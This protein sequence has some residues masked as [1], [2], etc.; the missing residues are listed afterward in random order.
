M[1]RER[2]PVQH[3]PDGAPATVRHQALIWPDGEGW[4]GTAAGFIREGIRRRE[5]VSVGVS[6]RARARLEE[7]ADEDPLVEFFD[8]TQVGRNPGRII[9]VML[10]F[11][12]THAGQ[13]LRYLSE[14]AWAGRSDAEYAEAVRHEV[15]IELAFTDISATILC[16]YAAGGLTAP[17]LACAEQTHSVID[18]GGQRGP[19]GR[20]VGRGVLPAHCDRPLTPPPADA[21]VLSYRS[22]LAPVRVQV[23]A[24]AAEAGLAPERV[25]DLVLAASEVAAN[26]LRHAGGEGTLR[27]W[28][29]DG[30]VVCEITDAGCITDPLT[31]RR[32][33][34][35]DASGQGLWVVNQVCD[36]VELRSGKDGT[37][38]RMHVRL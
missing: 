13:P 37:T 30:E 6:D 29:A 35:S 31:G 18:S 19:S 9:A 10:D 1:K 12:A 21:A 26:T 22:E 15:L 14:P 16:A 7:L 3:A 24:C 4:L 33:P 8:M 23:M 20:Y 36:L 11:A 2:E 27:T 34:V 28:T 25:T 38:V 32:R 17:L 5:P